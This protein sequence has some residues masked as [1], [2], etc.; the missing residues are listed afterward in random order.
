MELI[1]HKNVVRFDATDLS[2]AYAAI[3]IKKY[4]TD[5][6]LAEKE[7]VKK[8]ADILNIKN[9]QE[10]NLS[11]VLKNWALL[12]LYHEKKLQQ[13]SGLRKA[14]KSIF[15]LK[16]GDSEEMYIKAMQQDQGLRKLVEGL[17]SSS[18]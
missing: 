6:I 18:R 11:F 14:L 13:N 3:L 2:R 15:L 10:T 12:L 1:L 9:Y 8:L 17:I 7:T 5:R 4:K 16:A